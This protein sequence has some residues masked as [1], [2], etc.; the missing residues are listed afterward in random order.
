MEVVGEEGEEGVLTKENAVLKQTV[1]TMLQ[2]VASGGIVKQQICQTVTQMRENAHQKQT[3]QIGHPSAL[4]GDTASW[5]G[6][7]EVSLRKVTTGGKEEEVN[8]VLHKRWGEEENLL[9]D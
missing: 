4:S 6:M 7:V 8:Q 3:A 2:Y 5:M 1:Q 9:K